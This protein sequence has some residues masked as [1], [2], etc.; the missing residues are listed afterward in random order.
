MHTH[1]C[2]V[3]LHSITSTRRDKSTLLLGELSN[4][5]TG[6]RVNHATLHDALLEDLRGCLL[7]LLVRARPW[8]A[9][10]D[11]HQAVFLLVL[12]IVVVELNLYLVLTV[13]GEH[14]LRY[15][16]QSQLKS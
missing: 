15:I 13:S 9:H 4:D 8:E 2:G 3:H 5:I 7:V 16:V 1:E 12:S 6:D 11:L 10:A 14:T